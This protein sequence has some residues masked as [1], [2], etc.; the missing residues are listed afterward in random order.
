MLSGSR[1][2]DQHSVPTNRSVATAK[3]S[4]N[5]VFL[6]GRSFHDDLWTSIKLWKIEKIEILEIHTRPPPA[7]YSAGAAPRE[8]N[9]DGVEACGGL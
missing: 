3:L 9:I 1:E 6:L 7:L 5:N 2:G 8:A 4:G